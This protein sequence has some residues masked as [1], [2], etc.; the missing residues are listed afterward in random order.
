MVVVA[1]AAAGL[2]ITN[3][4]P[5]DFQAFAAERLVD[6][7]SEELCRDGGLPVLMRMAVTNCQE[8]VQAQRAA[9]GTVV[10]HHTR[11]SNFGVLSLYTSEIGGQSL[12]RWRVPRFRS[13]VVGVAG[14]FVL[15]RA[16]SDR[17]QA[18]Q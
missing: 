7:I 10:A 1:L 16:A 3:P 18:E 5:A 4:G 13:T 17:L 12:L 11:R 2:A 14:Q 9:L 15:V 8:L 6:E